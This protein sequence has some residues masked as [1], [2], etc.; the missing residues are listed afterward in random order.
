MGTVAGRIM[1]VP[2]GSYDANTLYKILDAVTLDNKLWLAKKSNLI[3]IEPSESN[4]DSWMLCVDGTTDV[5]GLE[6]EMDTKFKNVETKFGDVETKFGDVET[7]IQNISSELSTKTE[8]VNALS[9]IVNTNKSEITGL[10][11][12]VSSLESF[13]TSITKGGIGLVTS[14]TVYKALNS[15]LLT[16][17]KHITS[18]LNAGEPVNPHIT[19]SHYTDEERET[20]YGVRSRYIRNYMM[21]DEDTILICSNA[22]ASSANTDTSSWRPWDSSI[23]LS[24][25]PGIEFHVEENG[26]GSSIYFQTDAFACIN[27][28]KVDLGRGNWRWRNIYA[29]SGTITTSDVREK[30]HIAYIND[31]DAKELI[32]GLKPVT[33]KFKNGTSGRTHSG[34][35]AQEV[36]SLI[37]ELGIDGKD[38][39]GLVK[40]PKTDEDGN[41][42]EGDYTYGLRYEEFIAPLIKMCQNLQNEVDE[43]KKNNTN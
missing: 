22:F 19:V 15:E 12:R 37:G 2:K 13:D 26:S 43:L 23:R 4:I 36:E 31:V 18:S 25:T 7:Q 9:A 17:I 27:D 3:G 28:A 39:A 35:I 24:P 20:S 29:S 11:T 6:T 1:I 34:L 41:T 21:M 38:F 10:G 40:S 42:I 5:H 16:D 32:M 33:Y 14:G 30:D 8:D